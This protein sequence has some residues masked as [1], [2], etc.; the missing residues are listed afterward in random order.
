MINKEENLNQPQRPELGISDVSESVLLEPYDARSYQGTIVKVL[1]NN[2]YYKKYWNKKH[3]LE[4]QPNNN[5][6]ETY[7]LKESYDG[8]KGWYGSVFCTNAIENI[9]F[10]YIDGNTIYNSIGVL[11]GVVKH[12]H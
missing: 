5:G 8:K 10:E 1:P 9:H 2:E 6:K 11:V 3:Y 7:Y 12:S 4:R